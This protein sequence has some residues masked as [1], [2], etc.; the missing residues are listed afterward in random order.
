MAA[1]SR[2][3][4]MRPVV[5]AAIA[6]AAALGL[7]SGCA[8]RRDLPA[9][10]ETPTRVTWTADI[11]P[12]FAARC[13]SCHGGSTPVANYDLSSLEGVKSGGLDGIPNAV[14][15]DADCLL[16]LKA[17]AGG[18]MNTYFGSADEVALVEQWVVEDSLAAN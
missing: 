3:E 8:Q 6:F 9:A 15:G 14:A 16:L 11:Q 18:S 5:V 12:L 7:T 4:R 17:G 2:P 10:P 13:V 1:P